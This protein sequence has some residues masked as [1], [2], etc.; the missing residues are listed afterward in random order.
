F[1]IGAG[2]GKP[3]RRPEGE[4][5]EDQRVAE[6]H[7]ERRRVH[8]GH[9]VGPQAQPEE[10][11]RRRNGS[12]DADAQH[13]RHHARARRGGAQ[14]P[15]KFGNEIVGLHVF[16]ENCCAS[17]FNARCTPTFTADSESPSFAA[18]SAVE[19]PSIFVSRTSSRLFCGKV[20]RSCST[21]R[22]ALAESSVS[23]ANNAPAS[24]SGM[25]WRKRLR[26]KLSISL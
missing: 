26:R 16:S 18:V 9:Q 22:L 25:V 4:C 6:L 2:M 14:G 15:G 13:K 21:S 10:H 1:R 12:P 19:S 3:Q 23:S 20:F 7:P 5:G 17:V 24:S 8:R 11:Q